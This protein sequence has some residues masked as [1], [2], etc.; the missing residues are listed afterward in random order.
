MQL[1]LKN[2][3][4]T[5]PPLSSRIQN[6]L[7]KVNLDLT[8]VSVYHLPTV[9]PWTLKLPQVHFSLHSETKSLIPPDLLKAQFYFYLSTILNSFHIYTDGSKDV[10]GAA[11]A[12]AVSNTM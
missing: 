4:K 12:A 10:S 6:T 1:Y 5:I 9:N 2:R 11:A 7:S 8:V 3:P